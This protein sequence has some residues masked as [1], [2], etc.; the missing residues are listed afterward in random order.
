MKYF[1]EWEE[2]C[3]IATLGCIM[4][5]FSQFFLLGF[6]FVPLNFGLTTE[7]KPQKQH[8]HLWSASQ[9]ELKRHWAVNEP[10]L[11]FQR[12]TCSYFRAINKE[13]LDSIKNNEGFFPPPM[14]FTSLTWLNLMISIEKKE[15]GL[16][17]HSDSCQVVGPCRELQY[18]EAILLS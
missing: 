9:A 16:S 10:A 11:K 2:I 1:P 17:A 3:K 14:C 13:T 4:C 6:N 15:N 18:S 12:N 7:R 5:V 8:L